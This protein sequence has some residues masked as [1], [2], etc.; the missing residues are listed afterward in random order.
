M[1]EYERVVQLPSRGLLYGGLLP[2]GRV[3]V[4][5]MTTQEEKLLA[6][7][8]QSGTKLID[9]LF[10]R[11]VQL[12][13]GLTPDKLLTEDR[14]SLLLHIRSLSYGPSYT[15][16]LNCHQCRKLISEEIDL[17]RDVLSAEV[18][19]PPE[20]TGTFEVELPMA[21]KLL[22]LRF[23]TG[24]DEAAAD[25][26]RVTLKSGDDRREFRIARIIMAFD[27]VPVKDFLEALNFVRTMQSRDAVAI[28]DALRDNT[29]GLEGL[30]FNFVCNNCNAEQPPTFL[31]VGEDFFRVVTPRSKQL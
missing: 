13:E 17:D 25:K 30:E 14:F 16:T 29:F 7:S 23:A 4:K 28:R 8:S 21:A 19:M 26:R 20:T 11:L 5:P 31:P 9:A 2:E 12:P 6:S 1:P 22:T 3:T 15:V 18:P 27:G 24:E 10:R